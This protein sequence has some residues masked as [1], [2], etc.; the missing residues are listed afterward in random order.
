[1]TEEL[2]NVLKNPEQLKAVTQ[3]LNLILKVVIAGVGFYFANSLR[4]QV[5]LRLIEKQL[6]AYSELW[7]ITGVASPMR[8]EE[9]GAGPLTMKERQ[10]LHREMSRWYY[11]NGNGMLLAERTRIML[12]HTKK[13]LVCVP[14]KLKPKCFSKAVI[15]AKGTKKK[16]VIR[17]KMA[18]RQ[19]SLLRTRMKADLGMFGL[20]YGETLNTSDKAF[21]IDDCGQRLWRR[22]WRET[23]WK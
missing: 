19:L 12:L 22:P 10:S 5:R 3:Y 6:S 7:A 17:G 2:S 4:R 16:D 13:N 8:D 11:S 9:G 14:E 23:F 18:I 20:A 15:K 21:L 1:M